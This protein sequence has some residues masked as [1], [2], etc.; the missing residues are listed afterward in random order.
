MSARF[1]G[2]KITVV[3]QV[4]V[5]VMIIMHGKRE[6]LE[7]VRALHSSCRLARRLNG[8]QQKADEYSDDCDND[9]Q[10]H[11][12]KP[13]HG[14]YRVFKIVFVHDRNLVKYRV[15]YNSERAITR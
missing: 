5:D 14:L 4:V 3:W 10:F 15:S 13:C 2:D 8:G 12:G 11:E 7:I 1:S 9:E 6:L